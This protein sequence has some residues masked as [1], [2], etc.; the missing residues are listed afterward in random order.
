MQQDMQREQSERAKRQRNEE[1]D[2]QL[3]LFG[4][5]SG[6][7]QSSLPLFGATLSWIT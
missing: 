3:Q 6:Q 4:M 7:R 5:L 2:Y 1:G